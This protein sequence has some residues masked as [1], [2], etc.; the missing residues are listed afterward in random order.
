MPRWMWPRPST[1]TFD[2]SGGTDV[3]EQYIE[4]GETVQKPQDPAREG[5]YFK[6]WTQNGQSW[7]FEH[8]TVRSHMTLTAQWSAIP[9][10]DITGSVTD[11]ND[12]ALPNVEITLQQG[13][14]EVFTTKTDEKG[15]Y[16]F[17]RVT[18]GLYNVVAKRAVGQGEQQT[19]QTVTILVEITDHNT[20]APDDQN[21]PGERQLRAGTSRQR[22]RCGGGRLDRRG[23][24]RGRE[25]G[26]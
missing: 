25:G 20:N 23:H 16:T 10:F 5:S 22:P 7:D 2:S 18:P 9:V 24:S 26:K 15:N 1:V 17:E 3:E 14:T 4:D 21:A 11:Q 19:E 12:T 8:D 13:K 6:G